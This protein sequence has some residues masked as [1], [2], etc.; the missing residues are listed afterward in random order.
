MK[1]WILALFFFSGSFIGLTTSAHPFTLLDLLT[2]FAGTFS[3]KF[4]CGRASNIPPVL[5][6]EYKTAINVLNPSG[7]TVKFSKQAVESKSLSE[8]RGDVSDGSDETLKTGEAVDIDCKDILKL[9]KNLNEVDAKKFLLQNFIKG[10]LVIRGGPL[11][12][13]VVKTAGPGNATTASMESKRCL[14]IPPQE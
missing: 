5:N 7:G 12:V 13:E 10:F 14:P 11:V 6:G 3:C 9:L 4:V 2:N 8:E 1:K